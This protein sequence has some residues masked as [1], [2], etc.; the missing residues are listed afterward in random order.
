MSGRGASGRRIDEDMTNQ[1]AAPHVKGSRPPLVWLAVFLAIAL[2]ALISVVLIIDGAAARRALPSSLS[3][4]S[5]TSPNSCLA[6]G[7]GVV[8]SH[9]YSSLAQLSSGALSSVTANA[10]LL[11]YQAVSCVHSQWCMVLGYS[12]ASFK[13]HNAVTAEI[14][15]NSRWKEVASPEIWQSLSLS[16]GSESNCMVVSQFGNGPLHPGAAA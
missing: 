5:C 15:T 3:D 13:H 14:E 4:V 8:N 7:E 10:P 2:A 6:V 16:C 1:V 9:F 12:S 11:Y